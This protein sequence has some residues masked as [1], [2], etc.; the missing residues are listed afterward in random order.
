MPISFNEI[1]ENLR[2][3][4]AF[5]EFQAR[6]ANLSELKRVLLI[7][8]LGDGASEQAGKIVPLASHDDAMV[9]FGA[10]STLAKMTEAFKDLNTT[11]DV[12][13]FAMTAPEDPDLD[14]VINT[15]GDDQWHYIVNPY[16]DTVNL[17]K[18]GEEMDRRWKALNQ[19]DGR[20]FMVTGG[21]YDEVR[22]FGQSQNGEHFATLGIFDSQTEHHI[23]LAKFA[24]VATFHLDIDP[25]RPLQDLELPGLD[26]GTL[27][28]SREERNA[29]L[30]S[31]ISTYRL[32]HDGTVTLER[33]VTMYQKNVHGFADDAW[34]DINVPETLSRIRQIIRYTILSKF[35][36]YKLAQTAQHY[37]AGQAIVTPAMIK[38]EL[39]TLYRDEFMGAR[40]WV[41][42]YDHYKDT[43][44]VEINAHDPDRVDF[45][46]QPTLIGQFR[47]L[48]G[49]VAFKS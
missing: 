14:E 3:P 2:T 21:T 46:D 12:Y 27:N 38:A 9:K 22:S 7:G 35:P 16:T 31:G 24:A 1:P 20:V 32:Q 15:L 45:R 48:A 33:V 43:L 49:Q 47:I 19:N 39:L 37:G 44:L 34:L 11:L 28:L 25:A 10:D 4:G 8:E 13:G 41:Q 40:G 5:I 29:L 23:A 17:A 26:G 36:R 6:A 30:Y 42:D 18:L